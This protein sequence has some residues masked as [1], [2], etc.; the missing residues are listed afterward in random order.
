MPTGSHRV[1]YDVVGA[2]TTE[3]RSRESQS[4]SGS[5]YPGATSTQL[6]DH[7]LMGDEA[8]AALKHGTKNPP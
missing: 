2:P 4:I 3:R 8:K 1:H 5:R 7:L 6:F